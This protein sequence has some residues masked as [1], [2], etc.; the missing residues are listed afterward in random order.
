MITEVIIHNF[1]SCRD[2]LLKL[3]RFTMFV[4]PSGSGKTSILEALNSLCDAFRGNP[5]SPE[6]ILE[7]HK[8]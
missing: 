1:K 8:S 2:V 7:Q 5:H 3:E 4:G 6:K